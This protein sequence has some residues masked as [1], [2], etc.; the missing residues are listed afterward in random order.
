MTLPLRRYFQF[1]GRSSRKE[2]WMF[3]LL[4]NAVALV[5]SAVFVADTD[6][7]GQIGA[8]G[9]L[10]ALVLGL[11]ILGVLIPFIAVQVRRFHDQDKSGWFVLINLIPYLGVL[12]VLGFMLVP[13]VEGDNEYGPDPRK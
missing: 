13:G 10:A 4:T 1:E 8:I 7:W 2:F 11:G 9:M 5:L 6:M 3:M 12:I